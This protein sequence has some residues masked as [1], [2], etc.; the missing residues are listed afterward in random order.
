MIIAGLICSVLE[1]KFFATNYGTA[2]GANKISSYLYSTGVICL[3][4]SG[5]C[6]NIFSALRLEKPLSFIGRYSFIIYLSHCYF[7]IIL[8]HFG[9][10]LLWLVM[11]LL[12]ASISMIF[13]RVVGLLPKEIN[14]LL[15][16]I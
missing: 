11:W 6:R 9:L 10:N 7:I 5:K 2:Y 14:K 1:T 4:L 8:Q 13:A 16:I 12:V 15:G 3:T